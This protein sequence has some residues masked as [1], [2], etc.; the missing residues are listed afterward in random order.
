MNSSYIDSDQEQAPLD[1]DSP[2]TKSIEGVTTAGKIAKEIHPAAD[3]DTIDRMAFHLD[4]IMQTLQLQPHH[5]TRHQTSVRVAK[6]FLHDLFRGLNPAYEPEI[7]VLPSEGQTGQMILARNLPFQ[8]YCQRYFVPFTG[9]VHIAYL[10]NEYT[11][12]SSGLH[13]LVDFLARKPH[14]QERLTEEIAVKL[15]RYLRTDDVGIIVEA[16]HFGI[17]DN[18]ASGTTN[19]SV[20]S[21]YKGRFQQRASKEEFLFSVQNQ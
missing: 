17:D 5:E 8:S 21:C 7:P 2:E 4:A 19:T 13:E 3:N 6:Y 11:V 14:T 1:Q 16:E 18:K 12:D 9:K 20:T 10:P 15:A